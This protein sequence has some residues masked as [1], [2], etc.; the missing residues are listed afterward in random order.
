MKLIVLL[1]G[2]VSLSAFSQSRYVDS[3]RLYNCNGSI[4]LRESYN[5]THLKFINVENCS[6]VILKTSKYGR[7]INSY[8]L[9][10]ADSIAP[11]NVT[12]TLSNKVR[13]ELNRDGRVYIVVKSNSG[14]HTDGIYS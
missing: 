9:T 4:Q 14:Y 12:Y 5:Q 10:K 11:Y 13:A 6:N 1:L 2:L 3:A 8:K 7:V